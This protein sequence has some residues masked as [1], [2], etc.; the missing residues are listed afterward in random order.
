MTNIIDTQ[1]ARVPT[2][3]PPPPFP[4][5][6][7]AQTFLVPANLADAENGT[8]GVLL[9]KITIYFEQISTKE[10]I[11]LEVREVENG[12]PTERVLPFGRLVKRPS[13]SDLVA[14]SQAQSKNTDLI[15][16]PFV[17]DSPVYLATEKEYCFVLK[18]GFSTH[19]YRVWIAR[20]GGDD[21][22]TGNP[23]TN[24]PG[25]GVLFLST[26]DRT[27]VAHRDESVKFDL[28]VKKFETVEA[29]PNGEDLVLRNRSYVVL[30]GIELAT[31]SLDFAGGMNVEVTGTDI[32][33][34]ASWNP[35]T[36]EIV[37]ERNSTSIPVG[38][39]VEAYF[40]SFGSK[41]SDTASNGYKDRIANGTYNVA[42]RDLK[43]AWFEPRLYRGEYSGAKISGFSYRFGSTGDYKG[44]VFNDRNHTLLSSSA[45]NDL[46][47]SNGAKDFYAKMTMATSNPYLSPTLD[48]QAA[49]ILFY[50]SLI[51][52]DASDEHLPG[53]GNAQAKYVG[54][55]VELAEDAEDLRVLL[56]GFLPSGTESR[57]YARLLHAADTTN[58]KDQYWSRLE[59]IG[60]TIHSASEDRNDY[61]EIEY[62][63]QKPSLE[64]H[65][66]WTDS[67][68]TWVVSDA[69]Q[70]TDV[71]VPSGETLT[72][73][74]LLLVSKTVTQ[75][76]VV[77]VAS[78][79][80]TTVELE[81]D[82][83]MDTGNTTYSVGKLDDEH[84]RQAFRDAGA[85][86]PGSAAYFDGDG[87]RYRG[88]GTFSV[89]V[90]LV[91]DDPRKIP[92][93]RDLRVIALD[94]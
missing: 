88:F 76:R 55:T 47:T 44:A 77:K 56:T 36:K 57:A 22:E 15:G 73:G 78:T 69:D 54:Q 23:V 7:L 66:D 4:R 26:N 12:Y 29:N 16:T 81:E 21:V 20:L 82:L 18:P 9:G 10:N 75:Y 39:G 62:Q 70:L 64:N 35:M 67:N 92:S 80:G 42:A 43:V 94:I 68:A 17:F 61:I 37:V 59:R 50:E 53:G 2:P 72:A 25:V 49:S 6:P 79:T 85:E 34:I 27:W 13:D 52:A 83:D 19:E 40:P 58:I 48:R 51:D 90:V 30:G 1:T 71:T 8:D 31:G 14:V 91:S 38:D 74:D 84:A 93:V 46:K 11:V 33:S 5:D 41:P 63:I 65:T 89:K 87:R 86:I 24:D 3:P 60:P 45:N 28:H 32:G